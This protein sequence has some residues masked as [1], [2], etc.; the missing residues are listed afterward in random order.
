MK[1]SNQTVHFRIGNIAERAWPIPAPRQGFAMKTLMDVQVL[2]GGDAPEK[3][4][5]KHNEEG[6]FK[7]REK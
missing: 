1:V 6:S 3:Q 2:T 5:T 7:M 4:N